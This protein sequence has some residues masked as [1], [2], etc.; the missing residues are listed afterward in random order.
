MIGSD[1]TWTSSDP[2]VA[3]VSTSPATAGLVTAMS[4]GSAEIRISLD[5]MEASAPITVTMPPAPPP[6]VDVTGVQAVLSKRGQLTRVVVG[7]SGPLTASQADNVAMY[8]LELPGERGSFRARTT[9][10]VKLRSAD[11]DASTNTVA[12]T[13]HRP[14]RLAKRVE[15]TIDGEAPTGLE[16]SQGRLIDGN[17]D[18][19]AGGDATVVITLKM[20]TPR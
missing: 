1:V 5:G 18:G 20:S 4:A 17:H 7:F 2:S 15:L 6:L 19:N 9:R 10:A 14:L 12:L 8:R 13:L 3:T 11:Y 16:D